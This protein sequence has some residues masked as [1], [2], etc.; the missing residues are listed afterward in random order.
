MKPRTV[1]L[2]LIFFCPSLI[3]AQKE[4]FGYLINSQSLR[5]YTG[6]ITTPSPHTVP[7]DKF[8]FGLTLVSG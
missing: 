7:A 5:G 3:Y 6:N 4:N 1:L 8:I 2:L